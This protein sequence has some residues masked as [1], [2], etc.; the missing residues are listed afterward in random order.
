MEVLHTLCD[1]RN[2]AMKTKAG[3]KTFHRKKEPE[4]Y[5]FFYSDF[6]GLSSDKIT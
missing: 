3:L 6:S 4:L 5:V 1:A 2:D